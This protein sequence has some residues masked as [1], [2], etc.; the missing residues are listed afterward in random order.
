MPQLPSGDYSDL[1]KRSF[2]LNP[3]PYQHFKEIGDPVTF[4]VESTDIKV[5]RAGN[6]VKRKQGKKKRYVKLH[7]AVDGRTMEVVSLEIS[8]DDVNDIKAFP[9]L[10]EEA[11]K[12]RRI[13]Y[14]LGDGAYSS[15]DVFEA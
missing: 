8:T 10:V 12:R 4:A 2:A 5:H 3:N 1:R 11:E 15:N 13:S 9:V 6:W 14:W 7:F